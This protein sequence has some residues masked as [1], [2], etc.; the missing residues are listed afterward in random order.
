MGGERKKYL[1]S[2]KYIEQIFDEI[3]E[4]IPGSTNVHARGQGWGREVDERGVVECPQLKR[5]AHNKVR[6]SKINEWKS[7][8]VEQWSHKLKLCADNMLVAAF[9]DN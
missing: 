6:K 4:Q 2:L 7:E 5:G 9:S 1:F 8:R 3:G